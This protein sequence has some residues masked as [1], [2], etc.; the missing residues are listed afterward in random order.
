MTRRP[1]GKSDLDRSWTYKPTCSSQDQDR[2][3]VLVV[4]QI[5]LVQAG[6]HLALAV[7]DARHINRETV[8]TNAKF[9][10]SAKIGRDLGS[11]DDVLARQAGDVRARSANVLAIDDDNVLSFSSKRPGSYSRTRAAAQ[12]DHVEFFRVVYMST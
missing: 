4:F 8:V 11:V 3:G 5:H 2:A 7:T 6:H 9:L 1:V 10:A 12:N